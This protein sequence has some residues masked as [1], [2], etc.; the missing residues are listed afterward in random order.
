MANLLKN[1]PLVSDEGPA[2]VPSALTLSRDKLLTTSGAAICVLACSTPLI[3]TSLGVAWSAHRWLIQGAESAGLLLFALGLGWMI[4]KVLRPQPRS[5]ALAPVGNC[6]CGSSACTDQSLT[7]EGEQ[8]VCTLAPSEHLPRI[9]EYKRLFQD[10]FLTGERL[11]AGRLR[12]RF[13]GNEQLQH[14]LQALAE[15]E[16]ECCQFFEFRISRQNDEVWWEMWT[17]YEAQQI[18]EDFYQ[19]PQ[20]LLTR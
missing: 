19:I 20:A 8:I 18:L 17:S 1:S 11:T 14:S 15:K 16:H 10:T 12:W 9:N 6:G 7:T 5:S 4:W 3:L 13:R 2:S